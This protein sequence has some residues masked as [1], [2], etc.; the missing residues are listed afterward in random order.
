MPSAM[1][2]AASIPNVITTPSAV[3]NSLNNVE[4]IGRLSTATLGYQGQ[5]R[6]NDTMS[7][8]NGYLFISSAGVCSGFNKQ[9]ANLI[10]GVLVL[11]VKNPLN[12][13]IANYIDDPS[14][15]GSTSTV[16]RPAILQNGM[17][18]LVTGNDG[19]CGAIF[20]SKRGPGG[21]DTWDISNISKP[22][23]LMHVDLLELNN[24]LF[25]YLSEPYISKPAADIKLFNKNGK[26]YAAVT[27]G[28]G[29]S[30]SGNLLTFRIYDIS[31]PSNPQLVG[32]WGPE[33]IAFNLSPS[34]IINADGD[35]MKNL[36]N[37]VNGINPPVYGVTGG[38][39][40]FRKAL[41]ITISSGA[42]KAYIGTEDSG[43]AL[44]DISDVTNPKLIS[45][46]RDITTSVQ[47]STSTAADLT[48]SVASMLALPT[49]NEKTVVEVAQDVSPFN[50]KLSINGA[51]SSSQIAEMSFSYPVYSLPNHIL[52]SSNPTVYV[53]L[54][55]DS[56]VPAAP[57]PNIIALASRGTCRFDLKAANI[58]QK[59]YIGVVLLNLQSNGDAVESGIG[60]STTT[61]SDGTVVNISIP[62]VMVPYAVG[63]NDILNTG[64]LPALNTSGN[65]VSVS[66]VLA[67]WGGIRLWDYSNPLNP[68]LISVFNTVCSNN[69]LST[70]TSPTS[71]E[72]AGNYTPF[73]AYIQNN[74]AYFAW[75]TD[76]MIAVDISKPSKPVEI[77]RYHM[78]NS[79][80][81]SQN[82]GVQSINQIIKPSNSGCIYALDQNGGLYV[83][84]IKSD[85]LTC[86]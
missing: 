32:L 85:P 80:F 13:V 81:E 29:D 50:D 41:Q 77:A 16:A 56:S 83:L 21:F 7:Y 17:K 86:P 66:V 39:T 14:L 19:T 6:N 28:F 10:T 1:S 67:G 3:A 51:A 79:A 49:N 54:A 33:Q 44:L 18:V 2:Y 8:M 31:N 58:Q 69:P 65:P 37:Y 11:D 64:T 73:N 9:G 78:E 20:G 55:C 60:N 30:A 22:K 46:A 27:M 57:Q 23:H 43:I 25:S 70:A 53:G 24:N 35:L 38:D 47:G 5:N 36:S 82:N 26:D 62:M 68:Q 59:G 63:V 74:I 42:N 40:R 4:L 75:Y 45:Q 71:C 61:A 34:D 15:Q 76:G 48:L 12:P 72:K 52:T 84:H